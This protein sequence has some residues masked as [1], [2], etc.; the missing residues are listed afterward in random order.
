MAPDPP[1]PDR[2]AAEPTTAGSPVPE[3]PTPEPPTPEPAA[4]GFELRYPPVSPWTISRPPMR[5][6]WEEL[7]LL[8]W[9]Y[10]AEEVQALLPPG[11]AVET[12]DGSAWVGL[13]PF[14]MRVDVPL[15]PDLPSILHF[16]ETNVRTY[17]RD[18]HDRPGVWFFSLEAASLPA[19]VTARATYGVPYFWSTMSID[20]PG[21]LA[22]GD[23]SGTGDRLRYHTERRRWPGPSGA[24]SLVEVEVGE[25]FGAAE[26]G[27]LDHFLTA[28]WALFGRYGPLLTRGRMEHEPW[29]LHHVAV[30]RLHDELVT[31]AGLPAPTG[32]PLAHYSPIVH[33]R[34][35]WPTVVGRARRHL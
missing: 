28:R 3:P 20:T 34:C 31:A 23:L 12:F 19:V 6:T 14:R 22:A 30:H 5:M 8:H 13:V 35:G 1:A 11:V 25:P 26:A 16:P 21:H 9:R 27:P 29:P 18:R 24:S 4:P 32:E 7:T 2:S 10:R 17:V 15:L 33:V